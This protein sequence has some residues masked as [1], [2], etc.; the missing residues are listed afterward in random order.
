MVAEGDLFE[1]LAGNADLEQVGGARVRHQETQFLAIRRPQ[2]C[3]GGAL[4]HVL[5]V[6]DDLV[7]AVQVG[8]LRQL[9]E[10]AA[11]RRH[12]HDTRVVHPV[13]VLGGTDTGNGLAVG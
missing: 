3:G 12:R 8:V 11:R 1:P 5:G 9:R 13:R 6:R 2:G 4:R 10:S 7:G